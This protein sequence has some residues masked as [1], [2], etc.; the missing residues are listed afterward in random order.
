[1][2]A[3]NIYFQLFHVEKATSEFIP[4]AQEDL[5]LNLEIT[6]IIKSKRVSPKDSLR[7]LL[8]RLTHENPNVQL[9]TLQLFDKC[10]RNAGKAFLIEMAGREFVDV[11][12][13][14]MDDEDEYGQVN[15]LR[16]VRLIVVFYFY[17]GM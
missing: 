6:D 16:H 8:N 11:T 5:A 3:S 13:S 17:I 12:L 15:S 1:M 14:L 10:V 2:I 9:L 7:I 4:A